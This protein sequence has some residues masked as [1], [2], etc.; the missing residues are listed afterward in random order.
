MNIL[1]VEDFNNGKEDPIPLTE[2]WLGKILCTTV[3]NSFLK[4]KEND[5]SDPFSF[6]MALAKNDSPI[7]W[8]DSLAAGL[9][10]L[11]M[12]TA[13]YEKK[14]KYG[15]KDSKKIMPPY[16]IALLDLAIP[17]Q[18]DSTQLEYSNNA[19]KLLD[20]EEKNNTFDLQDPGLK[21]FPGII[22]ATRLMQQGMP[23]DRIFFLTANAD[24]SSMPASVKSLAGP[25]LLKKNII[26]KTKI[27]DLLKRVE[28]NAYYQLK[29][30]IKSISKDV[31]AFI[32]QAEFVESATFPFEKK[33]DTVN[34][35][36]EL[37]EML[38]LHV[39]ED[40]NIIYHS[41]INK[42]LREFDN[43]KDFSYASEYIESIPAIF[44][45]KNLK[46][47]RNVNA[48]TPYLKKLTACEV[49]VI[50]LL[51]TGYICEVYRG[52]TNQLHDHNHIISLSNNFFDNEKILSGNI[53]ENWRFGND[54]INTVGCTYMNIVRENSCPLNEKTRYYYLF[55]NITANL[56]DTLDLTV[57]DV[58]RM[59]FWSQVSFTNGPKD[60][61]EQTRLA[62][63]S[64]VFHRNTRELRN[65]P[66]FT[67]L[68]NRL[69]LSAKREE[70]T[71]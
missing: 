55:A 34:F 26:A 44:Y 47:L 30:L 29:T 50:F 61:T 22:L 36:Q 2:E 8:A 69:A 68:G 70:R 62:D 42:I 58:L 48:H 45:A 23:A 18:K 1:W 56:P 37:R 65:Q 7:V 28:N 51:F 25:K 66:F 21:E 46:Y 67:M 59:T 27:T 13:A 49:G 5:I 53:D 19:Q 9:A 15:S 39:N 11:E 4:L 63:F 52:K 3:K 31:V 54:F 32:E 12:G 60:V 57:W 14:K 16:E 40:D 71:E 20:A 33:K 38:P 43:I 35:L 41:I 10:A 24:V 6:L 17:Y 64:H